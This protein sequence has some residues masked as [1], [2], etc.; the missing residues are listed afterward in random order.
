MISLF[1]SPEQTATKFAR[2]YA[3]SLIF[4]K[5]LTMEACEV[6]VTTPDGIASV[7]PQYSP[8]TLLLA[9]AITV[10]RKIRQVLVAGPARVQG[11]LNP[12]GISYEHLLSNPI[13]LPAP[14]IKA[15]CRSPL[16]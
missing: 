5:S 15:L 2:E 10:D 14:Q 16:L 7:R 12:G 1:A 9:G 11:S 4:H 8:T 13:S 3:A 6:R